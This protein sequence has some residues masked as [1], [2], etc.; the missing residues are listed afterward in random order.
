MTMSHRE[1][2][3][4]ALSHEEPD[5]VPLD[6]GGTPVTQVHPDAYESLLSHIGF[7]TEEFDAGQQ[8]SF[9]AVTPS[10]EVLRHFDIDVRGVSLGLPDGRPN[11]ELSP[12]SYR[13]EWGVEW[14]KASPRAPFMDVAGPFQGLQEPGPGALATIE[15]PDAGDAGRIRGLR[16]RVE[17]L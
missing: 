5:R 6:M 16:E 17:A 9:Q 13:D 10:E 2:V 11:V 1:R 12:L 15:W 8:G 3:L 14:R 4:K 7:P